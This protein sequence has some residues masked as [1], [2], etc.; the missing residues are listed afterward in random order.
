MGSGI[1]GARWAWRFALAFGAA[2]C[3]A[4]T[5][6]PPPTTPMDVAVR[7]QPP[8]TVPA[9]Q[10]PE[11]LPSPD[12]EL[13]LC[14]RTS[15]HGSPILAM[16]LEPACGAPSLRCSSEWKDGT[17][18][19]SVALSTDRNESCRDGRQELPACS[20]PAVSVP[21]PANRY[22]TFASTLPPKQDIPVTLNGEAIAAGQTDDNGRLIDT[23]CWRVAAASLYE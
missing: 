11:V 6:E 23:T 21:S 15:H 5:S 17:L 16:A 20:L 9:V 7:P 3:G 4:S 2:A 18:H 14:P 8:A 22:P 19:L 12:Q 10:P 1:T 13:E